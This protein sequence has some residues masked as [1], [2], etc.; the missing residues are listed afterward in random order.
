MGAFVTPDGTEGQ[1]ELQASQADGS[2]LPN[3]LSFNSVGRVFYGTP[4]ND[5]LGG[6]LDLKVVGH[7]MFGHQAQVDVHVVLGH[8]AELTELADVS[9]TPRNIHESM[10]S[11]QHGAITLLSAPLPDIM[12]QNAPSPAVGKAALRSQLRDVGSMAHSRA[13]R[14]LLDRRAF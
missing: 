4:P 7:D 10:Q 2:P 11:L 6:T 13:A 1:L 12:V 9:E 5:I 14:E 3:W 8:K